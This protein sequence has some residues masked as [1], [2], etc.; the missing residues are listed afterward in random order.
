MCAHFNA[1]K[2]LDDTGRPS[3]DP[4]DSAADR[5]D[6]LSVRN[7]QRAQAAATLS[8]NT[9]LSCAIIRLVY[10][11][12]MHI[13]RCTLVAGISGLFVLVCLAVSEVNAQTNA[14]EEAV[15]KLPQAECEAWNKHDAHQL[16]TILADD[17]DFVTVATGSDYEK[18]HARLL[19]GR[20]KDSIFTP[21]ETA[22][23]FLRPDIASSIGVGR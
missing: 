20:F 21:L 4:E 12:S 5:A 14:D 17:G 8:A 11:G 1:P 23:R 18:F 13:L 19:A 22:V 10:G 6:Q 9:P 7:H 16:A 15:K 3:I 2:P